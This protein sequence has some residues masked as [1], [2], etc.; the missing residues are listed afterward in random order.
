LAYDG[1]TT[2]NELVDAQQNDPTLTG[3]ESGLGGHNKCESDTSL[4]R[5]DFFLANGD[6]LSF[7]G[8]VRR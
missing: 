5:N 7:N 6:N 4:T 1:I 3:S 2:V 8:L